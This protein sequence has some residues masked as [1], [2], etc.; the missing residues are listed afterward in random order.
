MKGTLKKLGI[1]VAV[2]AL[3][4]A[5]VTAP[6]KAADPKT[7]LTFAET[8]VG[9]VGIKQ[10]EPPWF[11]S[12]SLTQYV[13]FR[14]LFKANPDMTT[15]RPD[16]A[17]GYKVSK[18]GK[19]ITITLKSGL[20]WSDGKPITVDDVIW[21][22][23][24]AL[25]V[26]RINANYSNAFKLIDGASAVTASNKVNM[27]GLTARGN[28]LTIKLGA[29]QPLLIPT[30]AQFMILPKHVLE[31]EDLLR[32][33]TNRFWLNPVS[34]GPFKVGTLSPDNFITLVLNSNY[35][36]PKPSITE[37]NVVSSAALLADAR[38]GKIDYFVTQ[39]ADT[40]R[41]MRA[42]N[43]FRSYQTTGAPFHRYW[44]FNLSDSDSPLKN[45]KTRE[46][47]KYGIDWA[48]IVKAAYPHGKVI[49]S[50]VP[51]GLPF[52]LK[53]IEK[54]KFNVAK[55]RTLLREAN[56]DFSKTV[57]LRH[58]HVG[59]ADMIFMSAVAQ[60]MQELGMKVDLTRFVGDATTELYTNKNYDIALKGL[61]TFDVSEWYSEYSNANFAKIIGTQS[62]FADLNAQL[63]TAVTLKQRA[64]AL[65]GLQELEQETLLKLPVHL[66]PA[67]VYV[68][69]R[70]SGTPTK[71]GP[72][73]Y[74]YE[75]NFLN[76]SLS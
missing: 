65:R 75:N 7:S 60:Q 32:L 64:S 59:P 53:S 10:V 41:G 74:L 1:A 42:V 58:Y 21:S 8:R 4:L 36:G 44:V 63:A 31:N 23:N 22:I 33:D 38:S 49:N 35:E 68:S 25:R 3:A 51:S 72:W 24:S 56:F 27:S 48:N 11:N 71:Y 66:L 46:A 76:W 17:S 52:H 43:T 18:D 26:T 28:E 50:G 54:Y 2:S 67:Y 6:A 14:G 55:A 16:L 15:V 30:L 40:I 39:D 62:K 73:L 9:G 37:I 47:L 19:T 34:S 61:S 20:K 57:R 5:S 12:G 69:K 45:V 13:L 29:P 70:V